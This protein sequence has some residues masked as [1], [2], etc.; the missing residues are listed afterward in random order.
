[1]TAFDIIKLGFSMVGVK[2]N[3]S[4]LT[5]YNWLMLDAINSG[6]VEICGDRYRLNTWE[7]VSLD[8][9]RQFQISALGKTCS[10]IVKV[11]IAKDYSEAAG[12]EKAAAYRFDAHDRKTVTVYDAEPG[13][14]VW[15]NYRYLPAMLVNPGP[16]DGNNA[17][18]PTEIPEQYHSTLANK[19]AAAYWRSLNNYDRVDEFEGRFTR[20]INRITE[21]RGNTPRTVISTDSY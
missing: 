12:R 7:S 6:Y 1:M 11:S 9:N 19:A 15:V 10:D 13:A 21:F 5:E 14:T 4:L 17:T 2:P 8:A 20:D 3:T 18:S 16:L